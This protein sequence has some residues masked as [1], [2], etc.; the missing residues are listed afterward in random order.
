[1]SR[2]KDQGPVMDLI[3]VMLETTR[4]GATKTHKYLANRVAIHLVVAQDHDA[5]GHAGTDLAIETKDTLP[6]LLLMCE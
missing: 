2:K 5:H 6:T 1:M 4:G 3:V